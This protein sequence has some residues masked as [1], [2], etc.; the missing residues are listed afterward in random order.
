MTTSALKKYTLTRSRASEAATVNK[1]LAHLRRA[2]RLGLQHEPPLAARVPHFRMLPVD[3]A[4]T[5]IVSHEQY[6]AIRD[7]L[8]FYARIALV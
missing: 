8:P 3:N 1:E 2:F 4:R 6:R 5:G 7:E